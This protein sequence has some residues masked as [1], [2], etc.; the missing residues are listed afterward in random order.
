MQRSL[1]VML[2]LAVLTPLSA[3]AQTMVTPTA[4]GPW[5]FTASA[6]A[7]PAPPASYIAPGFETPPLG[8][9]SVHLA[10]GSNG[11]LNAQARNT[12]FAGTLLSSLTALSYSTYVDVD[13]SGGQAPYLNLLI[14]NDGNGTVDDQLFFE[15]AYQTGAYSG[16]PVPNQG[17]LQLRTWQT[18]DA[19]VGGW[20]ALSAGTFGPPLVT[21]STYIA[22]HPNATIV[23][24]GTGLG[25][26]RV[27]VG[28]GAGAW[29]NF[30]GGMD[31]FTID[32]TAISPITYNFEQ[33]TSSLVT[34]TEPS[35]GIWSL[36][37][38]DDG[39]STN[40]A[41][42]DIVTG[43]GTPP[44]GDGSLQLAVG[45]DGGDAA[46]ARTT[47]YDGRL[48]R[49]ISDLSY[50]TYV[51]Q[52]GS[53][54]QAPYILLDVDYNN[55]G[56]RDDI[57]FFEPVYQDATF[58]PENPQG[59]PVLNTWQQW[60]ARAGGWYSLNGVAG[61]GPGA[62][63]VALG[64]ILDA[65]PDAELVGSNGG[66]IRIVAGFGAGAWDNFIGYVDAFDIAFDTSTI[67]YDFEPVPSIIISDLSQNEGTG[68]TTAFVVTL[69]LSEPVTQTV[70]V[71]YSTADGTA[72]SADLDYAPVVNGT[73]TFSPLS[74]TT[75]IT[76]VVTADDKF[77]LNEDFFI[78]LSGAI[79][80]TISDPQARIEILNDDLAPTVTIDN[81]SEN[82]GNTGTSPATPFEFTV[83]LSNPTYLPVNVNWSTADGAATSPSDYAA[84][85][86]TLIIPAGAS[87]GIIA[88]N[89]AGDLTFEPNET[90]LV[91][92][93]GATN[94]TITDNQGQATIVNDDGVPTIDIND[95][96]LA[97]GNSAT[98]PFVFTVTLS[99]PSATDIDVTW[100]TADDSATAPSD[101]GAV[102]GT[103]T[104]PAGSTTGTITVD[105]AGD[106]VLESDE[107]FFV[108]LTGATGGTLD[109]AQ[110]VGTIQN[111]E[112]VPTASIDDV[113][114]DE[115]NTGSTA[116]TFTVTLTGTSATD[117][118][119][120]WTTAPGTATSNVDFVA[121]SGTLVIPALSLSGQITI[122]VNGE[123]AFEPNET[124][125]VNLTGASGGAAISDN[126]GTGTIINDDQP[127][128][129]VSI[130]KT[131]PATATTDRPFTYLITVSN[132]GPQTASNV[133]VT[134][135]IPTGTTFSSATPSQ[136][137]CTG[138]TV[139][140][141]TL[142]AIAAGGDATIAL[143]VVAG[144][145]PGTITNTASVAN[146]PEIDP[147]PGNNTSAPAVTA[148]QAV[149]TIPTVTE[150]G[151]LAL[152]GALLGLA[153]MKLR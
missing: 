141:C 101:Y 61:S 86:G 59:T 62:N 108:N 9:G 110:G 79:N 132:A 20:W 99:N 91:N 153:L 46:Q 100:T 26:V 12:A 50:W 148:A 77:E 130:T 147:T 138:T 87:S 131:A 103:L 143:T 136:G 8:A 88:I 134:D 60:D 78:N 28:S 117:V 84:A 135:T 58:F 149:T 21:L 112:G 116:F 37:T 96:A 56:V 48:V 53:G 94:A 51:Q 34:V 2:V 19:F 113:S 38:I 90:F 114:L 70:T 98:T 66:G 133:V 80:A 82:E 75:T 49:D 7:L 126:Q 39:D 73:A 92:L 41:T 120:T 144:P 43:P 151:I 97:E 106:A 152:L 139:V 137:S 57:L 6:S 18:W 44:E 25:G 145:T 63:V 111:D 10:V 23:N 32:T 76:I 22:A 15:P 45:A 29:D 72:T 47:A 123:T 95:V 140:T 30:L 125:F 65:E 52:F 42:I 1:A 107:T 54:G 68:G 104:I 16:D 85:S 146:T 4:P 3:A 109:D 142:G 118:S 11:G 127:V 40:T 124:F 93:T 119:I 24:T 83:S 13:G 89:V 17:A 102:S 5:Q 122:N 67:T 31:N 55:D 115:G 121:A 105:V 74:P 64:D 33:N 69:T 71:Q 150:W 14:D 35:P 129:D 27:I 81:P 128:A 36:Q